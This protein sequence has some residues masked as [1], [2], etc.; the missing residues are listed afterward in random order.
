MNCPW[1]GRAMTAG[2]LYGDRYPLK[3]LNAAQ[4]LVL[5]AFAFHG[6]TIGQA[7][8]LSRPY[9]TGHRCASCRKLVIDER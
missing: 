4:K 2:R 6:D 9:A 5:G 1:C 7:S 8:L 3:W